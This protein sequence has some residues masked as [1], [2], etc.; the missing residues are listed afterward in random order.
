MFPYLKFFSRNFSLVLLL[1]LV[2]VVSLCM[3]SQTCIC[4]SSTLCL[5]SVCV[6]AGL[7]WIKLFFIFFILSRQWIVINCVWCGCGRSLSILCKIQRVLFAGEGL[8]FCVWLLWFLSKVCMLL[9]I[10]DRSVVLYSPQVACSELTWKLCS[11]QAL[12]HRA[13]HSV[14]RVEIGGRAGRRILC[15]HF[16]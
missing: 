15:I 8:L 7:N 6:N 4:G 1:S 10:A 12:G 9:G 5:I 3:L 16:R 11:F 2:F 14:P 13:R